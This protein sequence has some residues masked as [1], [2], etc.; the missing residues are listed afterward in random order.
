MPPYADDHGR[1]EGLGG[2]IRKLADS[3]VSE[4]H[5]SCVTAQHGL[6]VLVGFGSK[7]LHSRGEGLLQ[8]FLLWRAACPV[9]VGE[10]LEACLTGFDPYAWHIL[11]SEKI[12]VTL[13]RLFESNA[14]MVGRAFMYQSIKT[15]QTSV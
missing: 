8:T 6:H 3:D 13:V 14:H 2:E 12:L 15:S 1:T 7:I 10:K 9:C 4:P 5:A 11:S